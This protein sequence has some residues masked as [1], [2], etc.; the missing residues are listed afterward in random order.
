MKP[1]VVYS[2]VRLGLFAVI[3]AALLL[4]QID[5][6]LSAAIA[7]VGGF[8][9]AYIFFPKLRTQVAQDMADRRAN[10]G[11]PDEDAVAEDS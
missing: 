2:L 10:A 6:F 11:K 3:L 5:P 1:W 4:L 9:L 7:A 8:C